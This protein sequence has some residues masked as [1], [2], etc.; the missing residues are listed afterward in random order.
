M[1][2]LPR[3]LIW[4]A[5]E[6]ERPDEVAARSSGV[7]TLASLKRERR[8]PGEVE[9]MPTLPRESMRKTDFS[10]AAEEVVPTAK[11]LPVPSVVPLMPSLAQGVDEPMPT[12]PVEPEL[13][14]RLLLLPAWML[15]SVETVEMMPP[16][17]VRPFDAA[18]PAADMEERVLVAVFD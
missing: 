10:P 7:V 4:K 12:V 16:L 14:R 6:V 13:S 18:S 15:R 8:A 3:E 11:T 9:A 17:R 2:T 1:P 5:V